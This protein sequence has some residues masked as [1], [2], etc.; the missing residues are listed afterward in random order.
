MFFLR[1]KFQIFNILNTK[2][3]KYYFSC[4]KNPPLT[5]LALLFFVA[6]LSVLFTLQQCRVCYKHNRTTWKAMPLFRSTA[7]WKL[8]IIYGDALHSLTMV[9]KLAVAIFLMPFWGIFFFRYVHITTY[10]P[11]RF[12]G[13]N[14]IHENSQ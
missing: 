3:L 9:L 2:I 11:A 14:F 4:L 5:L 6:S 13:H 7:V 10:K 1:I 8:W 12:V